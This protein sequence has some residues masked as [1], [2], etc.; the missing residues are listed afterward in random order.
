MSGSKNSISRGNSPTKEFGEK[1]KNHKDCE[2]LQDLRPLT[3]HRGRRH[4]KRDAQGRLSWV[5]SRTILSVR[6]FSLC[7]GSRRAL[8][9]LSHV[10]SPSRARDDRRD[11]SPG[12]LRDHA[13]N[14]VPI[15]PRPNT[16]PSV[17]DAR[18]RPPRHTQGAWQ[19]I[20]PATTPSC[21]DVRSIPNGL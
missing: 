17:R 1:G 15:V 13:S 20:V 14:D 4:I 8:T 6:Q 5:V 21:P 11:L 3:S 7:K 9:L 12:T 10:P 2:E 18:N 16:T 19:S